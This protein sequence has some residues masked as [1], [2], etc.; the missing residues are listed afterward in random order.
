MASFVFDQQDLTKRKSHSIVYHILVSKVTRPPHTLFRDRIVNRFD[1][2]C[3]QKHADQTNLIV[4]ALATA[5][6]HASDGG[7]WYVSTRSIHMVC[8][9]LC[10]TCRKLA[11]SNI[12]LA[13]DTPRNLWV[14]HKHGASHM[15]QRNSRIPALRAS[16]MLW[17]LPT[18]CIPD[19]KQPVRGPRGLLA[20]VWW[21]I[22]RSPQRENG[23]STDSWPDS[24]L[25]MTFGPSFNHSV[26]N[27]VW[28]PSFRR[29]VFGHD[30]DYPIRHV[31][32]PPML[33]HLTFGKRFNQTIQGIEWPASLA[34]ITFGCFFGQPIETVVWPTSLLS[35]TFGD[36][37]NS[38]IQG[39]DWPASLQNLSFGKCFNISL[40]GVVDGRVSDENDKVRWPASLRRLTF[41]VAFNQP[42]AGVQWPASLEHLASG[43]YFNQPIQWAVAFIAAD[44]EA[45]GWL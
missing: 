12:V 40:G 10:V 41:G 2:L 16:S 1:T 20:R 37:F 36:A 23:V 44:S 13:N 30:F 42:I 33:E 28:P 34:H 18:G 26:S 15:K 5:L 38:P 27:I 19:G 31:R 8:L 4:D 25:T 7:E 35:L 21:R 29:V 32:W 43:A 45:C 39:V 6:M 22:L 3:C 17:K 24:L 9:E 14:R 11:L